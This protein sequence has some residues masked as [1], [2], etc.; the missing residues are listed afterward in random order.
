MSTSE[1]ANALFISDVTVRTHVL[2]ILR[3]LNLPDRAAAVEYFGAV[4]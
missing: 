4:R 1:I 3:Q 2:A